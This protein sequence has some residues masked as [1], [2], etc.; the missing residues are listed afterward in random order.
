MRGIALKADI[1]SHFDFSTKWYDLY[2]PPCWKAYSCPR[3]WWP[4]LPFAYMLLNVWYVQMCCK[5]YHM[6]FS[7]FSLKFKGKICVRKEVIH[8]LKNH[9]LVKW[10]ATIW[11][12]LGKWCGFEKPNQYYHIILFKIWHTNGTMSYDLF[13]QM[14]C[15]WTTNKGFTPC[16]G[17]QNSLGFWILR[18]GFRI[19]GTGLQSLSVKLGFW[20]PSISG[21]RDSLSCIQ[22]STRI[23][24]RIPNST[25]QNFLD[26]KIPLPLQKDCSPSASESAA[27]SFL[28]LT[29]NQP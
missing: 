25:D 16:K 12:I 19:P 3:T 22:D 29:F 23:F 14:A 7:T 15:L 13:V 11:L 1:L 8:I 20:I 2:L 27:P 4:K 9:I 24:F 18:R 21:N 6:N 10:P 26:S 17:T 28:S 5:R